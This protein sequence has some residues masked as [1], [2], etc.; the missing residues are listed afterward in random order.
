MGAADLDLTFYQTEFLKHLVALE[1][2]ALI[3]GGKARAFYRAEKSSDLDI[4]MPADNRPSSSVHRCL[5]S[6]LERYPLHVLPPLIE[7]FEIMP[8]HMIQLPNADVWV[9]TDSHEIESVTNDVRID[10]LFGLPG[11]S[12]DEVY[13]KAIIW[14]GGGNTVRILSENLLEPTSSLKK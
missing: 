10:I 8:T 6:W 3:I 12:F 1:V 2:P 14:D 5:V 4:W 9:L 13:F 7:P 11:F